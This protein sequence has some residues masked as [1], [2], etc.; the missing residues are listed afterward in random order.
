MRGRFRCCAHSPFI[1]GDIL[2][3]AILVT[4]MKKPTYGYSLIEE[5]GEFGI[6][7]A[8]FHPSVI[9][10]M[11]RMMEMEGLV[12][13]SWDVRDIGPAR[14]VYTITD[15][16][17]SFLKS[18]SMNAKENLKMIEKLIKAIEEGGE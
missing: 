3:P 9:Y 12:I 18:W 4:L 10:R 13:S 6:N 8:L 7:V 16:G 1:G 15:I 2:I 17:K 14:R 5:L 11:L